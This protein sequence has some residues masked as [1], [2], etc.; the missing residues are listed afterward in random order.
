LKKI[1]T[2]GVNYGFYQYPF[3]YFS[4]T[5]DFSLT[6]GHT[7]VKYPSTNRSGPTVGGGIDGWISEVKPNPPYFGFFGGSH[8]FWDGA[9]A[10]GNGNGKWDFVYDYMPYGLGSDAP[11]DTVTKG[12]VDSHPE[13]YD[14]FPRSQYTAYIAV[15]TVP[16]S[17][18]YPL[19]RT[20]FLKQ[21]ANLTYVG[22]PLN[23]GYM[24]DF[25][26]WQEIWV[27]NYNPA[28][29][30]WIKYGTLPFDDSEYI[31]IT[32]NS[33]GVPG[34]YSGHR[35]IWFKQ[36]NTAYT[37]SN[38]PYDKQT[39]INIFGYNLADIILRDAN[40]TTQPE[41]DISDNPFFKRMTHA[42]SPG[43]NQRNGAY[44]ALRTPDNETPYLMRNQI[45][46]FSL[47]A[48]MIDG[49]PDACW[50][51]NKVVKIKLKYQKGTIGINKYYGS[52]DVSFGD[53]VGVTI[54]YNWNDYEEEIVDNIDIFFDQGENGQDYGILWSKEI[55]CPAGQ[56]KRLVDVCVLEIR[57]KT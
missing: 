55:E 9:F 43:Y 27:N 34:S 30:G 6:N 12:A 42:D 39:G 26:N 10:V 37:S 29:N 46:R 8:N 54:Q 52:M 3:I 17:Q 23:W 33:E 40:D 49:C 7:I 4:L 32:D 56:A 24:Y 14:F 38:T 31:L 57:D 36:S 28:R 25:P 41:Y 53:K 15:A 20:R 45:M 50:H 19:G 21:D 11:K 2:N 35:P 44:T 51:S 13:W 22:P 48:N 18:Q 5:M 1:K 16:P 47:K